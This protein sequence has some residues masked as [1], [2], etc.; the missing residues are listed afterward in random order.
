MLQRRRY[1]VGDRVPGQWSDG[2]SD[3]IYEIVGHESQRH[4]YRIKQVLQNPEHLGRTV[5][6]WVDKFSLAVEK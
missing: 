1:Q 4:S 6:S 2:T 5:W 3:R